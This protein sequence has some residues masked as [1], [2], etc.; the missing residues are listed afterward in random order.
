MLS[1]TQPALLSYKQ[2][3]LLQVVLP[4][5]LPC[6]YYEVTAVNNQWIYFDKID[7]TG[8]SPGFVFPAMYG[9]LKFKRV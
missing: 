2:D 7:S 4:P 6:V 3:D 8:K 9:L 5:S 1:P